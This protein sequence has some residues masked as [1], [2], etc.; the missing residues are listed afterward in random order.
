[1]GTA[2]QNIKDIRMFSEDWKDPVDILEHSLMIRHSCPT[3]PDTLRS[4]S[5]T[6]SDP[7]IISDAPHVYFAGNQPIY[8]EKWVNRSSSKLAY[9]DLE[10]QKCADEMNTHNQT[11]VISVPSFRT[12]KK[13]VLLDLETLD[14]YDY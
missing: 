8:G 6:E 10:E 2:G 3:S 12:T 4:Y 1:M 13:F 14:C 7:F 5:F 11:K 9:P